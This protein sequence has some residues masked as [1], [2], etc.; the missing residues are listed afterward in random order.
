MAC[1]LVRS[2]GLLPLPPFRVPIYD[3]VTRLLERDNLGAHV[4]S[5][6]VCCTSVHVT[7]AP[8]VFRPVVRH[9]MCVYASFIMTTEKREREREQQVWLY[10]GCN[11][12]A[13]RRRAPNCFTV[14]ASHK[15][16][17]T[18]YPLPFPPPS[19]PLRRSLPLNQADSSFPLGPRGGREEEEGRSSVTRS[20]FPC[21]SALLPLSFLPQKNIS[22]SSSFGSF[23]SSSSS[24]YSALSGHFYEAVSPWA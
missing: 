3:N 4:S 1:S 11:C 17:I 12:V 19:L 16:F 2:L 21:A 24:F 10:C 14:P 13:R 9:R 22:M 8:S 15:Y 23:G 7:A 5:R 20:V 6:L 18:V